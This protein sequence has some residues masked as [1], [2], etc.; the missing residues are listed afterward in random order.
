MEKLG[1]IAEELED[2]IGEIVVFSVSDTVLE[3]VSSTESVSE[4]LV[5]N[6]FDRFVN[7]AFTAEGE[8]FLFLFLRYQ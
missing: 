5:E 1:L 3:V 7:A 2:E 6:E 8:I 4:N